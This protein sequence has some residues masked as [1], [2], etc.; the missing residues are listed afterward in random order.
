MFE[1]TLLRDG[2]PEDDKLKF[3]VEPNDITPS[4]E[5]QGTTKVIFDTYT[6]SSSSSAGP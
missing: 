5:A 3:K 4:F 2:V 1:Q 6:S